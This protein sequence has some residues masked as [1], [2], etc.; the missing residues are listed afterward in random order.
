MLT[1]NTLLK[2][3]NATIRARR[4][5]ESAD[6]N[7]TIRRQKVTM[8]PRPSPARLL[9]YIF[10]RTAGCRYDRAGECTMCNYGAA[11]K[12]S[13][14]QIVANVRDALAQHSDYDALGITPLGNM[15]DTMEVPQAARSAIIDLAADQPG[16]IFSCESR[17]ETLTAPAIGD[18]VT[19]L[20]GKRFYLNLGLEAAHSWVQANCVGKSLGAGAFDAATA[21]L[22]DVGAFPVANV[23]LGAPFLTQQETIDSAVGTIRWALCHGSHLCVLFPANVKGWTLLDWLSDR[24]MFAVP[25]LWSLVEV[26]ARLG[27]EMTRSVV[28]SWY[29]MTPTEPRR[30]LRQSDPLRVSPTTCAAC[31]EKVTAGLDRFNNDGDFAIVTELRAIACGC[32]E[33]WLDGLKTAQ[34][35][36]L[37]VRVTEAYEAIGADLLGAD[38]WAAL[39]P[40]ALAQ[41][42]LGYNGHVRAT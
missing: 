31:A 40:R 27:P 42:E 28:L 4:P 36:P 30:R 10:F 16:S 3:G 22:R 8:D 11:E 14:G 20:R 9:T 34:V 19:R 33:Q 41:L 1:A 23:L 7:Y 25:S 39:R 18:A 37:I 13:A 32:R 6:W 12:Q 15:F 24:G 29:A 38:R 2:H 17:P 21:L 26:L 35:R 5:L